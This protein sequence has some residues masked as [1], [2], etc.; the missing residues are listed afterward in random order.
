MEI[1]GM[2]IPSEFIKTL[3]IIFI[4]IFIY[5][6]I[7]VI[8]KKIININFKQS[9]HE[10]SRRKTVLMLLQNVSKYI[11]VF[12]TFIS[13]LNTFHVNTTALVT[14]VGAISVVIG[15][16]FQDLLKDILVGISIM[17]EDTFSLGDYIEINGFK[18]EVINFNFKTTRLKSLTNEVRIISNRNISEVTNYSLNKSLLLVNINAPYE[19]DYDKIEKVLQKIVEILKA[20]N[21]FSDIVLASGIEELS[22]SSVVYRINALVNIKDVYTCKREILKEV[23][24]TFDKEN[25]KIP[26]TQ[27]EVHNA[28]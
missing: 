2:K 6:V 3:F 21:I 15:L 22:S 18:G 11:I 10:Q 19:E 24:N 20:N 13:I 9:K 7:K 8:I 23:K 5:L 25:I 12:I 17:L 1:F 28:K 26:Y 16:A 27:I 14:G 4:A